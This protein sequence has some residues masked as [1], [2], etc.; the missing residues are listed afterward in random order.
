VGIAAFDQPRRSRRLNDHLL[1]GAA[2]V[3]RPAH[4]QHLELS[5]DDVQPLGDVL[6]DPVQ[7]AGAAGTG[8]VLDV[9]DLFDPG[10][11]RRQGAAV[12]AP[13]GPPG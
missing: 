11:V 2:G 12:R 13:L 1:A 3:L 8:L 7:R 9:D 4:H 10:Q 6:A 5:R